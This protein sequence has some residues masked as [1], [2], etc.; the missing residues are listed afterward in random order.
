MKVDQQDSRDVTWSA[1]RKS[2]HS[3]NGG[4]VEV[5]MSSHGDV[6]LRDSKSV[7][8]PEL[9]FN[10]KEWTAFLA[11]VHGGEFEFPLHS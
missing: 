9:Q 6:L 10:R 1:F 3:G 8:S 4:C 2:S 5:A 11:G 7:D